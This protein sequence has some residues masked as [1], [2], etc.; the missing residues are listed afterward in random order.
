MRRLQLEVTGACNL[1]CRMCLVRYRPRLEA[2]RVAGELGMPL[3]LPDDR[4][5]F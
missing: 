1:R 2:R 3:R 4:H 5:V